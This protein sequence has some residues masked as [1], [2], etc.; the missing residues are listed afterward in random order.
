MHLDHR[1]YGRAFYVFGPYRLVI[2]GADRVAANGDA[3]NKIGTLNLAILCRYFSIPFYVACPTSPLDVET[4]SGAGIDIERRD[5]AE[6]TY[7]AGTRI[8][9]EHTKV[10]NPGFDI[11]PADL[12]S[13]IVTEQGII[14]PCDITA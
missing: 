6:V 14:D 5:P 12:I 9:P 7:L 2:V 1:Q 11:T 4:A 13:G 10:S 3:A 8:A